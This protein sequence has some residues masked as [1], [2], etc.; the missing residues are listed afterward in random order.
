MPKGKKEENMY[1][2]PVKSDAWM[3]AS[4]DVVVF[5]REINAKKGENKEEKIQVGEYAGKDAPTS[6][7]LGVKVSVIMAKDGGIGYKV[8]VE[9]AD[10][11]EKSGEELGE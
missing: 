9:N 2:V 7:D 8:E 1:R 3:L 10:E 11:S 6:T 5:D 4:Y